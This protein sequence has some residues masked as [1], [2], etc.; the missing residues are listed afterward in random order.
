MG[1]SDVPVVERRHADILQTQFRSLTLRW[2]ISIRPS[3]PPHFVP[4][5][6]W[7]CNHRLKSDL[8]VVQDGTEG[9]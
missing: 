5:P 2:S 3:V 4:S 8:N 9:Q 6:M 1:G 7:I